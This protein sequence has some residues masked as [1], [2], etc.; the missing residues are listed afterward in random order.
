MPVTIP[1]D[2]YTNLVGGTPVNPSSISYEAITLDTPTLQ[3]SWPITGIE[4]TDVVSTIIDVDSDEVDNQLWMPNATQVS[5]GQSVLIRNTGDNAFIIA[6]FE[7]ASEI[8]TVAATKSVFIYLTDT[9][10]AGGTWGVVAYG[11]STAT[12]QASGL[13]GHGL[14]SISNTLNLNTLTSIISTTNYIITNNDRATLLVW[15]GGS[16]TITFPNFSTLGNGWMVAISN[17]DPN[18]GQVNLIPTSGLIDGEV[19]LILALGQTAFFITDGTNLFSVGLGNLIFFNASML[20][21]PIGGLGPVV[22]ISSLE[23]TNLIQTLTGVLTEDVTVTYP[24][25]VAQYIIA[26]LT[27]GS[28]NVSITVDGGLTPVL[29]PQGERFI[30]YSNGAEVFSIPTTIP[31]SSIIFPDG[32]E[33]SPSVTFEGDTGSGMY[34][35]AVDNVNITTGS[36]DCANFSSEGLK[37]YED[38]TASAPSIG[39]IGLAQSG[40]FADTVNDL[41]KISVNTNLAV[42]FGEGQTLFEDGLVA[43]PSISLASDPTTGLYSSSAGRL[44]FTSA[45]VL[46]AVLTEN[47]IQVIDGSNALPGYAF[48]SETGLGA[49]RSAAGT[50]GIAASG[51][52]ITT[53]SNSTVALKAN[54]SATLPDLSFIGD[55]GTGVGKPSANTLGLYASGGARASLDSSKLVMTVPIRGVDGS[56]LLPSYTFSSES[57]TGMYLAA[58][59]TI[60]FSIGGDQKVGIDATGINIYDEL[61]L[62]FFNSTNDNYVS[63]G[64]G[65]LVTSTS[66][67]LPLN[68]PILDGE[69]LIS[70]DDGIMSWATSTFDANGISLPNGAIA[71]PAVSFHAASS[72][73]LY[74]NS[75]VRT[76]VAG[77]EIHGTSSAGISIFSGKLLTLQNT[78]NTFGV[79][80]SVSPTLAATYN[81]IWPDALPSAGEFLKVASVGAGL[82]TLVW[83]T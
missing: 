81:V 29:I 36:S 82:V 22:T 53:F 44:A 31:A 45:G 34:L 57:T 37:I 52:T 71:T 11:A 40:L 1:N 51:S 73:G 16:G 8:A 6:D 41:I 27:T 12:A 13:A 32:S 30:F 72:T 26:N 42:T 63:F 43:V 59:G 64:A 69:P 79:S 49:F 28:F 21:K 68:Y 39:W 24:D 78:T 35:K 56:E 15:N 46:K 5:V 75:G 58:A 54:A 7:G 20:N 3:L 25:T 83:G 66:Y 2:T 17:Q 67:L 19:N 65:S 33:G 4:T 38:G 18:G 62:T 55:T 10:T 74:Y 23:A 14:K 48:N 61:A 50:L 9:S 76:V 47:G 60:G 80:Q 77:T 70:T